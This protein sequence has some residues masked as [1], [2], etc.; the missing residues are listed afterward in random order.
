MAREAAQFTYLDPRSFD[1][2]PYQVAERA[3]NQAAALVSLA[4]QAAE[5]ANV[6]ARNAE[7]S[8]GMALDAEADTRQAALD[9]EESPQGSMLAATTTELERC[10][11]I[12]G[13]VGQAAAYDPKAKLTS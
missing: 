4:I 12:L 1:G 9:W 11:R 3:C 2:T 6:M 5:D 10:A 13:A 7:L 8:R